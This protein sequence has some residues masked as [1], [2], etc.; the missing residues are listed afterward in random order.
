MVNTAYADWGSEDEESAPL[1]IPTEYRTLNAEEA[2]FTV[3]ELYQKYFESQEIVLEPD[4]PEALC[5][6][7]NKGESLHRVTASAT[8]N[9]SI[10]SL[11][12]T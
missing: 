10:I 9:S 12:R 1:N 3:R 5:L 7:F 11:G 6:G 8:S 4:F 2:H